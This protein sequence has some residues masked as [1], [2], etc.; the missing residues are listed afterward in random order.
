MSTVFNGAFAPSIGGFLTVRGYARLADIA[1]CSFADN[2]YQRDL[3][4]EHVKEI[5]KFFNDGEYLF[6][7]EIILSV[8]LDVD[9][10][11][12]GA[13]SGG[14]PFQLIRDGQPFKSNTNGLDIKP[15]KPR[16]SADLTRYEISMP[17]GEKLFKRIDGNH[18]LSAF[19]ALKDVEFDRYVAPFCLV[20]FGNAK[21]ARRNEKALFHN[22]NSKALPLTSEE[23][24][25]GIVDATEDFSNSDLN[26]RF[27]PEYLQCR[28]LKD[29]LDFTYL[30]NL[31]SVFGK[32]AGQN[33]CTRS[34]LIQSLQDVRKQIDP[35]ASLDSEAVFEAIKHINDTYSDKR[36]QT[37]TAQ[38]LFA[39]FMFFQLSADRSRG[40][41]EQFT[42]WVLR[43]HQYELQSIHAADLVKIFGKIA[44]SRK[45]QVFVSMQFSEDTKPNFDAIKSAV[46]DLNKAH[47]LDI[48]IRPIRIDQFDTGYSY[49]INAEVLRLI[50]DSGLLIADLTHGNKNVYQEIGYLMG[51]NQGKGFAHE[52]FLLIHNG[53]I[54][55]VKKDIGFNIAGIKQLRL[56]DTNK[57]REAVKEQVSKFYGL[58]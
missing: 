14:D 38:G 34:V 24:F 21:D 42:N 47:E 49:G 8:Q 23:V 22:I 7:P 57:L 31:K 54:G 12:S 48:E 5:R 28:Q 26:D 16:S 18:R 41:Y 43:T 20:F 6:F 17:D 45:R 19:E 32:C 1:K 55:D 53:S 15:R 4:P 56:N 13:P 35:T 51:L 10:D 2:A 30:S 39:A 9:Y 33:E 44:Q 58:M 29:R 52:N 11:K 50:E 46:D 3:K 27:G 40:T 25:K 36:L 37:S